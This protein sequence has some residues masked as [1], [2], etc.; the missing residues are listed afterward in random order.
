[1]K[2]IPEQ[3]I[4]QQC[5][6][7]FQNTYCLKFH[8]PSLIIF[9]VPNGIAVKCT[10]KDR[11]IALD[12]LTKTGMLKGASDLVIVGMYGR[13]IFP[14]CK[15]KTGTQQQEQIDFENKIKSLQGRYFIFRNLEQFKTEILKNI[16]WLLGK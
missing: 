6:D 8:N 12:L 14:E 4:Q 1:M 5:R 7:W 9:S 13:C 3:V 16:D 2:I 11:A 10:Q 15:D